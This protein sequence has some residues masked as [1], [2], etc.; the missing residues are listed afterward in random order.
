MNSMVQMA[1][2]LS[3][4]YAHDEGIYIEIPEEYITED[5]ID[6]LYYEEMGD[7]MFFG[8]PYDNYDVKDKA[9]CMLI[10]NLIRQGVVKTTTPLIEIDRIPLKGSYYSNNFF[11]DTKYALAT[12]IL[13]AYGYSF[14]SFSSNDIRNISDVLVQTLKSYFDKDVLIGGNVSGMNATAVTAFAKLKTYGFCS[15]DYLDILNDMSLD[16]VCTVRHILTRMLVK[17][18]GLPEKFATDA[19][20]D[21]LSLMS[22]EESC[23]QD[24]IIMFWNPRLS[25]ALV[26]T[27]NSEL[28]EAIKPLESLNIFDLS[29]TLMCDAQLEVSRINL[30]GECVF[31][32]VPTIAFDMN[33]IDTYISWGAL[34]LFGL[35]S[36]VKIDDILVKLGY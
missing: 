2:G 8:N 18:Y 34:N 15:E 25:K 11:K 14:Y 12:G 30:D 22:S 6:E 1:I 36:V 26:D 19:L 29:D 35:L 17:E 9:Y 31:L 10:V 5:D 28:I 33:G 27:S 7:I 16:I 20:L 4:Q 13:A 32:F 24:D 3:K 21:D 23:L